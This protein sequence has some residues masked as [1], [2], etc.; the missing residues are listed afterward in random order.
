MK[1]AVVLIKGPT[2]YNALVPD[3]PGVYAAGKTLAETRELVT[4]AI[5]MHIRALIADNEA[6][7]EPSSLSTEL[8]EVAV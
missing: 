5:D 1:Y 4:G 6:V 2:G 8:I 3:L 7:P